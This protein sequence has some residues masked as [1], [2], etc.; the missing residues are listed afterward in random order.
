[1]DISSIAFAVTLL[2]LLG[3]LVLIPL[4]YARQDSTDERT[5][6]TGR[7]LTRCGF[8]CLSLTFLLSLLRSYRLL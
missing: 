7:V 4:G 5:R 3:A 8:L 2:S 6:R 1:M